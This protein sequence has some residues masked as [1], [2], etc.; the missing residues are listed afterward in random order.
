MD[1]TFKHT[2][3]YPLGQD[4]VTSHRNPIPLHHLTDYLATTSPLVACP[5]GFTPLTYAQPS[6]SLYNP[7]ARQPSYDELFLPRPEFKNVQRSPRV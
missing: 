2:D 3:Q 7:Y 4:C 6:S 1:Q 5:P